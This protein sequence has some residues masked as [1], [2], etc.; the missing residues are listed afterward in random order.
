[1]A[2]FVK[3]QGFAQD[4]NV[5]V[6]IPGTQGSGTQ[7]FQQS[8][9]NC[10][11]EVTDTIGSTLATIYSDSIGTAKANP[12][13]AAE[14]GQWFFY[15][16]PGHEYD[17]TFSG[18][19]IP[20]PFAITDVVAAASGS[21]TVTYL[22]HTD[23]QGNLVNGDNGSAVTVASDSVLIVMQIGSVIW[24]N[25]Y[26]DISGVRTSTNAL[27][28]KFA[29]P[30][31]QALL[32]PTTASNNVGGWASF[33]GVSGSN[34]RVGVVQVSPD[35]TEGEWTIFPQDNSNFLSTSYDLLLNVFYPTG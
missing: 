27:V 9:P 20:F 13:T 10:L 7:R 17:I 5:A 15:A 34:A 2:Q 25:G 19:G 11:I 18:G 23:I 16:V 31:L 30:T 3:I 26:L 35:P 21:P 29:T 24:A 28:F 6:V 22:S 33:S 8:Y 32:N 14:D 1:M 12:F 4:G